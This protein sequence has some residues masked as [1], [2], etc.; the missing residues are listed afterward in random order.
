MA[1]FVPPTSP[2]VTLVGQ[3]KE[4]V[5]SGEPNIRFEETLNP[6]KEK[7]FHLVLEATECKICNHSVANKEDILT[8]ANNT[9]VVCHFCRDIHADKCPICHSRDT[10]WCQF[11]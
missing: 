8:C 9:H 7:S 3:D 1:S 4:V 2:E 11:K 6:I 5:A 10:K